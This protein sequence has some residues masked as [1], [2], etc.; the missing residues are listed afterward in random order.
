[1]LDQRGPMSS[2]KAS[3]PGTQSTRSRTSHPAQGPIRSC[4]DTQSNNKNSGAPVRSHTSD[5][6]FF[7]RTVFGEGT[8][9]VVAILSGETSIVGVPYMEEIFKVKSYGSFS[10]CLIVFPPPLSPRVQGWGQGKKARRQTKI[11]RR[12]II[13]SILN[14]GGKGD[15]LTLFR[16]ISYMVL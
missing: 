5:K 2:L 14:S 15:S 9:R 12:G 13:H 16:N 6:L 8:C 10:F 7:L 11:G 3:T 4:Q 1:M